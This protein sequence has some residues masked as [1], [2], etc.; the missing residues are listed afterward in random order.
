MRWRNT[1]TLVFLFTV[2]IGSAG[3]AHAGVLRGSVIELAQLGPLPPEQR[4]EM[5]Q[6]MREHWQQMPPEERQ[7]QRERFR[8]QRQERREAFQQMPP[9]DRSR[10]RDE[11]RGRR[12]GFDGGGRGQHGEGRSRRGI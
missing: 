12:E 1:P 10:M 6:Q 3:Q 4:R 8:E 5:R 9:E 11:L 7:E 2:L